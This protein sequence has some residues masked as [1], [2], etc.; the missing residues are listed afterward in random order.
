MSD[1]PYEKLINSIKFLNTPDRLIYLGIMKSA[2]SVVIGELQLSSE[3]LMVNTELLDLKEGDRVLVIKVT[4]DR[5]AI[6]ERL[7][8]L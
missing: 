8:D 6:V 1:R 7:R 3:D 2:T 5:Y 4:N